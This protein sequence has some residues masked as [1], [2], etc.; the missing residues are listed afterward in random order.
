MTTTMTNPSA[1]NHAGQ[2]LS[3][4]RDMREAFT[5]CELLEKTVEIY[6]CALSL[7]RVHPLPAE[8]AEVEKAYFTYLHG[9]SE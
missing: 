1:W 9:E 7:G 3:V 5:V 6:V 8:A 4:G 2:L